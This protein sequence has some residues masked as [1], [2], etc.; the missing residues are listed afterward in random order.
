MKNLLAFVLVSVVFILPV[1]AQNKIEWKKAKA[2]LEQHDGEKKVF[3]DVYTDWCGW[4][5]KMDKSTFVDTDV[6]EKMNKYFTAVKF[7]AE[8]ATPIKFKDRIYE[9]TSPDVRRSTHELAVKL[10]NGKLGYPSFVFLDEELNVITVV[11]G[12]VGADEFVPILDYLGSGAYKT[13]TW[14]EYT[15]Q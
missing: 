10:L 12:Y 7:D 2:A 15:K 5:K 11:N 13:Q 4:C 3:I 9:N 14:E 1:S 8:S 6:A